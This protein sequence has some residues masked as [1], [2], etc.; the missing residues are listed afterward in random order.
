MVCDIFLIG[1][2]LCCNGLRSGG[3]HSADFA[4]RDIVGRVDYVAAVVAEDIAAGAGMAADGVPVVA[5]A[6]AYVAV[7]FAES[8][9]SEIYAEIPWD[10]EN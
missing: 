8:V 9:E 5:I 10:A 1:Y 2:D 7:A 6:V 4:A 3:Q